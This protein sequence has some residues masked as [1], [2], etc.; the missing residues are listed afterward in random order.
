L[1][2][3]SSYADHEIDSV[4]CM[5]FRG[6]L[7]LV[8]M[9]RSGTK[10]LREILNRNSRVRILSIETEFL[11]WLVRH[12]HEYGDV[13]QL[14]KFQR[15]YTA[16]VRFPYFTYRAS[17]GKLIDAE[18]WYSACEQF[19]SASIF[20]ALVRSEIGAPPG[21][22]IVWGDKSPSYIDDMALIQSLYP[23]ARF[24]HIIRDARDY[25]LSIHKAWGK[26]MRRAAQRWIDSIESA[27][28]V[29]GSFGSEYM[30]IRYEDLLV[31]TE[32]QVRRICQF[33]EV[34]FDPMM[35][36]LDRAS[37]NIGDAKGLVGIMTTNTGKYR[38]SMRPELLADIESMA[39]E[40]LLSCGYALTLPPRPRKRLGVVRLVSAQLR[41]GFN[42]VLS[43]KNQRGTYGAIVFFWRYFRATRRI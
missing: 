1:I 33:I 19:D 12:V 5:N 41:D 34:A 4:P 6:P 37:E 32:F 24:I 20:E 13:S 2:D 29:G 43:S 11:P 28:R 30:E 27:R 17:A 31:D 16:L 10:L 9:P 7:F 22:N 14:P 42:L 15:L 3:S 18:R 36:T 26:D 23:E 40:T 35:L 25:C 21:S 38:H 8:G 39:G